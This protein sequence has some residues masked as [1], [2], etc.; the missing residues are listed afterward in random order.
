MTS[1][2]QNTRGMRHIVFA[3]SAGT[4]F[5]AFDFILFG[6]LAPLIATQFFAGLDESSAF[7]FALLSFAAGYL[8]R[9]FGALW[10]GSLGDRQGRKRAFLHTLT[11]MGLATFGIG[12]LPTY[13]SAGILA[14]I[15]LIAMRLLQGLSFGGEFGGALVYLGEHAPSD[16]RAFFSSWIQAAAGFA[17]FLAFLVVYTTRSA[18]G[19]E[20]FSD[21]GWR[22]P[23]LV[24]LLL[25][26]SA[27]WIR[28]RLEESPV[29]RRMAAEGRT[30]RH[31]VSELFGEW[32][33]LRVFGVVLFGLMLPQAV[34]FY[35]AHF[36]SQFFLVKVLKVP[37]LTVTF[38][39]MIVTLISVPL[40]LLC[41]ALADRVGRKPLLVAGVLL[42]LVV[43]VPTFKQFTHAVSPALAAAEV[44]TPIVLTSDTHECSLQFDPI[45]QAAFNTS[46]DIAKAALAN[47]GVSYRNASGSPGTL[48]VVQVG[49]SVIQ[50]FDGTLL[51]DAQ[52]LTAAEEFRTTL[53]ALLEKEGYMLNVD[54]KSVNHLRLGAALLLLVVASILVYVPASVVALELFPA[55][56]RYTGV[57]VP[58]HIGSGWFGGFLPAIAFAMVAGNGSIYFG[59]WYPLIITAIGAVVLL[60]WVPETRGRTLSN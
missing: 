32:R 34:L 24:S 9:P 42:A 1:T 6:A 57:S 28:W 48:A 41:G 5:E 12:L 39:M 44:Q 53:R 19:E 26:V 50:S 3:T 21:W 23:F 52:L 45:G 33:N 35:Q 11:I 4:V 30:S 29:F 18:V 17:L 2:L 40:Y 13:E 59:L 56:I 47:L 8:A 25:L 60:L 55:R 15:L 43:T 22:L 27:L 46:C 37:A 10:F 38:L 31:P 54:A 36:Y 20:A 7:V 58:Y 16:K 14:P 51:S 49:D